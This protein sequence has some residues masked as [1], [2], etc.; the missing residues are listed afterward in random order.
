M[1][2]IGDFATTAQDGK[3]GLDGL[4]RQEGEVV[5]EADFFLDEGLA[6]ADAGEQAVESVS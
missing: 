4:H 1:A 2:T 3:V 6:V 5:D